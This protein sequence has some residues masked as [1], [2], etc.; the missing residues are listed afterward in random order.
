MIIRRTHASSVVPARSTPIN[1]RFW[2]VRDLV[3]A[4]IALLGAATGADAAAVSLQWD[5]PADGNTAGYVLWYGNAPGSYSA[6]TDI[7]FAL[8]YRIDGLADDT[9][10]CF[11]VQA[12]SASGE[13]S[14][15][16]SH[17]CTR[18]PAPRVVDPPPGDGD[19]PP[20]DPLGA[21][22]IVLY[23]SSAPTVVGHWTSAAHASAA[24]GR[25]LRS[26]DLGWSRPDAPLAG[27]K[28]YF[29]LPFEA[30]ANTPYRVW[31]RLRATG[32]SKWN[33]SVWVQFSD[34]LIK[35][36]AA[37]RIGTTAGLLVNL[38][39]CEGCGTAGWGWPDAAYW[40]RQTATVTF[41]STGAHTIRVQ[42]REDGVEI[43]Q[44]V[45]SP[46]KYLAAA[47]GASRNDSTILA[48]TANAPSTARTP[49]SGTPRAIPGTVKAAYF[50]HG[51]AGVAY[52][53]ST[54]GNAGKALRETDVD[55]QAS[56]RG[57]Y[58]IAFTTA[59]EWVSYTVNVA[60]AGT[61]SARVRVASVGGG[62]LQI[63]TGGAN[64]TL[65]RVNVPNTGGWQ[66]WQTVSVPLTVPAGVQ[67]ITVRFLTAN[68]NLQK[69]VIR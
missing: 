54:P 40:L 2:S 22:E 30:V 37:Y 62:T 21:T 50:D 69:I 8:T 36:Q 31:L 47:P 6:S 14:D 52:V 44:I 41:A 32:D 49:Y 25:L 16:S 38:E 46:A 7:G 24:E 13:T 10:Y 3:I 63:E 60:S 42:T 18:T 19:P 26:A 51:R 53:D 48:K 9:Q 39:T 33:D 11:V 15:F 55:V 67:T 23:T 28:H 57:G 27:P 56:I 68:I 1:F 4:L 66:T 29:E 17:V 5:A 64:K 20:V 59:G 58:H 35:G 45:L 43:D 61:Y 34:A 65:T 12:Y